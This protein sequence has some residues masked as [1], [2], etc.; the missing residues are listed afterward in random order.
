[1][2]VSKKYHDIFY[3]FDILIFSKISRYFPTVVYRQVRYCDHL[4]VCVRLCT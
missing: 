2:K 4:C 1:L 3:I